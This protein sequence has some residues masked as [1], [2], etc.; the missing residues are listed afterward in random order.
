MRVRRGKYGGHL[1]GHEYAAGRGD[2]FDTSGARYL[3]AK[4]VFLL[5][6]RVERLEHWSGMQRDTDIHVGR[7]SSRLPVNLRDRISQSQRKIST[8]LD[9]IEHEVE[10]I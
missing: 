1:L 5:D 2:R 3:R 8:I 9:V 4:E 6:D 10:T 7:Q